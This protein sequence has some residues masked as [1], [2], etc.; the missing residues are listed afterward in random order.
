MQIKIILCALFI[1]NSFAGCTAQQ[2]K[3]A[4]TKPVTD[5]AYTYSKASYDGI[6]KFYLGREISFV[7]GAAASDW[8]ERDERDTE[9]NTRLAIEKIPLQ[10][11]SVVA[12]IGAG[13]GY[14]SF[15]IAAR[16]PQGKVFAVD[17]Q[18]EMIEMLRERKAQLKDST[19]AV[20]KSSIKSPNLPDNSTDLAIMVDVYHELEYPMEMLQAL[21][22]ALKPSGKIL[23]I[24]YRGEDPSVP[25]KPL[26]KTTVAQLNKEMEANGFKLSYKGDFLP[27]QHFLIYEK[28][29]GDTLDKSYK[30]EFGNAANRTADWRILSDNVMGGLSE[31]EIEY[32]PA[33]L[34]LKGILSLKNRGGFVSVKSGFGNVDLSKYSSISIKFRATGQ[35]YAFTLENSRRW[36]EPAYKQDFSAAANNNW[37]VVTLDLSKFREE[38]IGDPTGNKVS[39]T[40][41]KGILRLGISTAEKKEGPFSI[42]IESVSFK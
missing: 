31:A 1:S 29:P 7:M 40:I 26:H 13:T 35:Q 10:P 34:I 11:N 14:Y 12:D 5:A 8:L 30:I 28:I 2:K 9:E 22:K 32:G 33:S 24:E 37:Q 20:I 15:R 6:G 16:V 21:R 42:E 19:V 36:Y 41:L 23:L 39:D 17:I 18:D 4:V 3:D 25:I 38:V 27:I